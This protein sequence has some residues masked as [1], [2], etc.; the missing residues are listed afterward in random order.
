MSFMRIVYKSVF[1]Q[2]VVMLFVTGCGDLT[3]G[4]YA[5]DG[6]RFNKTFRYYYTETCRYDAIGAYDCGKM[7]SVSPSF[8]VSLRVDSDGL[9]SL[10]LDGDRY[11]YL[12]NEYYEGYDG[13]YGGYFRFYEDD[14]KLDVYRD[15]N[16]L[17][18]WGDDGYVTF[19]YY[20]LP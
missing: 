9:A 13:V 1:L 2:L 6:Y 15:G 3:S 4:D 20:E 17:A 5:A 14:G 16:T 18:F 11:Y 12:E 10:N 8:L 19:Y 7:Y